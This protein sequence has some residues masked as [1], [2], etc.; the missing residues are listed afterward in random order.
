MGGGAL[1]HMMQ[2]ITMGTVITD[3]TGIIGGITVPTPAQL[4]SHQDPS[5][6]GNYYT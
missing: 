3:M 4:S 6:P 2:T 1:I 5:R